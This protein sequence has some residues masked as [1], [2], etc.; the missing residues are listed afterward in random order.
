M[1]PRAG[2]GCG[3]PE[4]PAAVLDSWPQEPDTASGLGRTVRGICEKLVQRG[5]S[6]GG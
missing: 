5:G 3:G 6:I 4:D 1:R 2:H